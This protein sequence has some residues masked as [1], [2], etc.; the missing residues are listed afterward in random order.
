MANSPGNLPDTSSEPKIKAS[1]LPVKNGETI[2]QSLLLLV[3][4]K[5]PYLN[6]DLKLP[7]LASMLQCPPHDLSQI[8]NDQFHQSFTDFI[9]H[10]RV[11]EFK[12]LLHKDEH[13]KYTLTALSEQCGFSSRSSFFRIFKNT[14]GITPLEYLKQ[15]ENK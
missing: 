3:T 13:D 15:V 12:Q 1:K 5:K 14:T 2:Q 4:E 11:E 6:P 9:N 7:E 8:L 10:Y